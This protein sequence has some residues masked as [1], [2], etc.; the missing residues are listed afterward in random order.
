DIGKIGVPDR[1]LKKIGRLSTSEWELMRQHPLI[2]AEI[3]GQLTVLKR[4][5]LSVRHH[6]EHFDGSGYPEGLA[7]KQIP[8]GARILAVAD[9]FDAITS[10]R[11]YRPAKDCQAA[12]AEIV[13]CSP[14]QFDPEVVEALVRAAQ[15]QKDPWPVRRHGRKTSAYQDITTNSQPGQLP[16]SATDEQHPDEWLTIQ[17][18]IEQALAGLAESLDKLSSSRSQQDLDS[19]EATLAQ[20]RSQADELSAL[21][22]SASPI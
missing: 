19:L 17:S 3:L 7:G 2:S 21:A 18:K 12:I 5:V 6:H 1:V 22:K 10:D 4:E 16:S 13:C 9:G 20:F 14:S 8:I 15:A 11:I